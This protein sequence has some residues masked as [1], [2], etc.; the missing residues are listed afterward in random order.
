MHRIVMFC[1]EIETQEYFTAR[2]REE[3]EHLGFLV[4][5]FDLSRPAESLNGLMRF[6]RTGDTA[7]V[8][9]NYHGITPG[10]IFRL[11]ENG[12]WLWD[13]IDAPCYNI[14]VDHPYYYDRFMPDMPK[15]YIH[16]SI[17]R[18]HDA[19]FKRFYPGFP[20]I[21]FLPLAG[22][23]L[24]P[25]SF[26]KAEDLAEGYRDVPEGMTEQEYLRSLLTARGYLP[27]EARPVDVVFTGNYTNPR[28]FDKYIER[29]G[30]EYAEFYRGIIRDLIEHSDK[31]VEEVAE[32]HIRREIPEVTED[33]LRETFA[34]LIFIDLYVRSY[35]R[36]KAVQVLVDAGLKVAVFGGGW[37]TLECAHPENLI[38]GRDVNSEKCLQMI[39]LAKCSL[40]V[41]PWF[42]DGA[43]DR[44]FNTTLNGSL[45][46][47]DSSIYLQ[48]ILHDGIDYIQYDLQNI[49]EMPGRVKE[50]LSDPER[51]QKMADAAYDVAEGSHTW[52]NRAAALAEYIRGEK[53]PIPAG[54]PGK[55][56]NA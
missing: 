41:M 29:N 54:E 38:N 14:V 39:E 20:R 26:L 30:E 2:M 52:A 3:F 31:T 10:D 24:D 34:H 56:E 5:T 11:D 1:G 23:K 8:S 45:L 35:I 9:F 19:Y 36:G 7:V 21:P 22:T 6:I 12:E 33:E 16:I 44:I 53:E 18:F 49:E 37:D 25:L 32:A 47:S 4:Y 40:N 46:I 55:R 28:K 48:E 50:V 27:M 42:K 17:D 43:H 15:N 51:M 13:G